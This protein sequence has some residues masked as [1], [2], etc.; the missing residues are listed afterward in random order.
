MAGERYVEISREDIEDWL[1]SLPH[2][3]S[4]K[5]GRAGIY[6]V[7]FSNL[8]GV[9]VSTTIGNADRAMA[10]AKGSMSLSLVSLVTGKVLNKKAKDRSHFQ[11]T[12]NWRKTW[13]GGVKHWHGVYNQMAGFY[14]KIAPIE[15]RRKYKADMLARIEA[16]SGWEQDRMLSSFHD[17]VDR[18]SVLSDTQVNSIQQ[19][20][21]GGGRGAPAAPAPTTPAPAYDGSYW[22]DKARDLYR[23]ARRG[24]N[25]FGMGLSKSMGELFKAGRRDPSEKQWRSFLNLLDQFRIQ[26][27]E[28][29]VPAAI[30]KRMA[31]GRVA[32]MYLAKAFTPEA[33]K[34][35]KQ[36]HPKADPKN[37]TISD[38]KG[39]GK[40]EKA[41]TS[42]KGWSAKMKKALA[43]APSAVRDII[44]K[45]EARKKALTAAAETIKGSK[46]KLV[47]AG[48]KAV[49]HGVHHHTTAVE[50]LGKLAKG[51]PISKG[52]A[53]TLLGVAIAAS[54]A[55]VTGVLAGSAL[56]AVGA[57]GLAA[58]KHAA[59][60]TAAE[61]MGDLF[62]GY[63]GGVVIDGIATV[64]SASDR[65]AEDKQD[66][67]IEKLTEAAIDAYEK[68]LSKGL[69]EADIKEILAS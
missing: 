65:T 11:R 10:R 34:A 17:Q 43:N 66:K 13:T 25:N 47:G 57:F 33:W 3:W 48:K 44:T 27:D 51:K 24:G 36:D 50:S 15:D 18:N 1:R 63:E 68:G 55:G 16:I 46:A 58:V 38:G 21:R 2:K 23:E 26:I 22:L 61:A 20:E 7:H 8:V 14:E 32:R 42:M 41:L 28:S 67:I 12:T 54:A 30:T 5:Q 64:L 59:L 29:E 69:S 53:R 60:A 35:Y 49:H 56:T 19:A 4:R 62:V 40:V 6:Y 45:P 37:H 39:P 9:S 52:E 31:A